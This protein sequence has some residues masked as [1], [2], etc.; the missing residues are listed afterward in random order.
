MLLIWKNRK[1]RTKRV[2]E[3]QIPSVEMAIDVYLT[4]SGNK[5]LTAES[6]FEIDP[7]NDR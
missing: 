5:R 2:P 4:S 6:S 1:D 7:L 3:L